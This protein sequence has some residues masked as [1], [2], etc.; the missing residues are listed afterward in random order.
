MHFL[1]VAQLFDQNGDVIKKLELNFWSEE[2]P[3]EV[4]AGAH[5]HARAPELYSFIHPDAWQMVTS[6]QLLPPTAQRLSGLPIKEGLLVM[7]NKV[8]PGNGLGTI[9]HPLVLDNRIALMAKARLPARARQRFSSLF[10][11]E[12]GFQGPGVG[13][14]VQIQGPA[15]QPALNTF[16]GFVNYKGMTADN[17]TAILEARSNLMTDLQ[18]GVGKLIASTVLIREHGFTPDQ[19]EQTAQPIPIS[20]VEGLLRG[21]LHTQEALGAGLAA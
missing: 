2:F 9:Y 8:D 7:L 4:G 21:G 15:E 14:S 17:A 13:V 10:I 16:D 18:E 1:T 20:R 12:V 6:L 5:A 11:H 3:P 19:L